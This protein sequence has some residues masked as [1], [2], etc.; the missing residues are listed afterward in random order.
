MGGVVKPYFSGPGPVTDAHADGMVN[1]VQL[2]SRVHVGPWNSV[3]PVGGN[4]VLVKSW[5]R[6]VTG[7]AAAGDTSAT[8]RSRATESK[9]ERSRADHVVPTEVD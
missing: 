7:T 9:A 6:T 4:V 8:D 1:S 5:L 3:Q 2:A